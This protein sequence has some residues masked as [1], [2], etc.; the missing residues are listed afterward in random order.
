M[1]MNVHVCLALSVLSNSLILFF[2]C[3]CAGFPNLLPLLSSEYA[4]I[5]ELT[6]QTLH[7]C[8]QDGKQLHVRIISYLK[9]CCSLGQCRAAFKKADGLAKLTDFL[10]TKVRETD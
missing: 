8:L 4:I 6:L 2:A 9:L 7:N 3:S 5:Q 10:S 1:Y